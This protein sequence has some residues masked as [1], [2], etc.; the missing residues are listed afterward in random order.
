MEY[1]IKQKIGI[2]KEGMNGNLPF[3]GQTNQ[4][5]GVVSQWKRMQLFSF[6]AFEFAHDPSSI[7]DILARLIKGRRGPVVPQTAPV[8]RQDIALIKHLRS[9]KSNW[10]PNSHARS[11]RG[12]KSSARDLRRGIFREALCKETVLIVQNFRMQVKNSQIL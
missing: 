7:A 9:Q 5:W 4:K 6:C 3:M 2:R 11:M 10:D 1:S 8:L 12:G